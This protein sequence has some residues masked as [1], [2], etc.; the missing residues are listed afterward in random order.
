[1]KIR[2]G[3]ITFLIVMICLIYGLVGCQTL[4]NNVVVSPK[5]ESNQNSHANLVIP[6]IPPPIQGSVISKQISLGPYS[7][8][9]R[10]FLRLY[11]VDDIA[12]ATVNGRQVAMVNY[13][14]DSGWIDISWYLRDGVNTIEFTLENGRYGGWTY[15]FALQQDGYTIWDDS[16]GS[17][18]GTDSIGCRN[19]DGTQGLVYGCSIS[20]IV[21]Y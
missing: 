16:C 13:K 9:H 21:S 4:N 3:L 5:I 6:P 12:R 20:L 15:G 10:Y 11:N 18:V 19:N 8:Q 1:M 17:N 14:Q 7:G 2:F